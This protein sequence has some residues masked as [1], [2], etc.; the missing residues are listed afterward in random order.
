LLTGAL[1][2]WCLAHAV[3]AASS[4]TAEQIVD[5]H[6][7]ARGGL[8]AWRALQTLSVR[9]TM[10]AG[11]TDSRSASERIAQHGPGASARNRTGSSDSDKAHPAQ[12]VALPFSL[13]MTRTHKSRLEVKF[14]GTTSVQVFD[15]ARGW[16]LRP[17]L[18]RQDV[19]P[20]T[21]E[22]AKSA[23]DKASIDGPL[24]DY[25]TKG[26]KLALAGTE[27]V[28]GRPAY[29]L[30]LTLQNGT[31]QH[32]WIDAQNFLDVKI[33]GTPRQFDG[34]LRA[35]WVYQRDFRRV[36]NLMMP[37]EYETTVDGAR[38]SHRMY[39]QSVVLNKT[40]DDTRFAKP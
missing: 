15:G 4:L 23:A 34:R 24:V 17:F 38:Q 33:E 18:N 16:K 9:G 31:V 20:F 1:L 27:P 28:D 13:E 35:V 26:T 3:L 29:K 37:Y 12:Q 10:E 7:A 25:T 19:E 22:E 40:L 14:S 2:C 6:I 39:F 11:G 36:D 5:R 8:Q 30:K 32:I 21:A